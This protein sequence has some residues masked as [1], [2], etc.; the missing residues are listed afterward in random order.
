MDY[1]P[2]LNAL[3]QTVR[4]HI[5]AGGGAGGGSLP[6]W[7]IGSSKS[8]CFQTGQQPSNTDSSSLSSLMA[9]FPWGPEL[10]GKR[11]SLSLDWIGAKDDG[12]GGG[13]WRY[14]QM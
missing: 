10:A 5:R 3:S 7:A 8:N 13:N 1:V 6:G 4:V 14:K 2:N 9:T 12:S 11:M